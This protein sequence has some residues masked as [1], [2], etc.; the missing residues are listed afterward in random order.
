MPSYEWVRKQFTLEN[1]AELKWEIDIKDWDIQRR[2]VRDGID[3]GLGIVE[4]FL[5][6]ARDCYWR[7]IVFMT[8]RD[9]KRARL[10]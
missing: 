5:I 3:L 1:D 9:Q 4:C 6:R 8:S 10:C 7:Q 2:R